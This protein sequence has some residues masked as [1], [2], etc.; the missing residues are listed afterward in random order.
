MTSN[1]SSFVCFGT[2]GD[3]F[4]PYCTYGV[5]QVVVCH[6]FLCVVRIIAPQ[7]SCVTRFQWSKTCCT[8]RVARHPH[9]D[10]SRYSSARSM[11]QLTGNA[12]FLAIRMLAYYFNHYR[13]LCKQRRWS[14]RD[15]YL[16]PW[17]RPCERSGSRDYICET[18]ILREFPSFRAKWPPTPA[19]EGTRKQIVCPRQGRSCARPVLTGYSEFT[20]DIRPSYR[21]CLGWLA[22]PPAHVYQRMHGVIGTC[23]SVSSSAPLH[24]PIAQPS[25]ELSNFFL[26]EWPGKQLIHTS[27]VNN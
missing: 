12:A 3:Y 15:G 23:V 10:R 11:F 13:Q 27:A 8:T 25:T 5:A 6:V 18:A 24:L 7:L 22:L 19:S 4:S 20:V 17:T 14:D 9:L 2:E 21:L 26:S 16:V 1:V